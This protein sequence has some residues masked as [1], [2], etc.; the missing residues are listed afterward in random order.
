MENKFDLHAGKGIIKGRMVVYVLGGLII[1][2]I[3]SI[4][5][6][7]YLERTGFFRF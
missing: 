6:W 3:L 5:L 2:G 1:L 7:V 4:V